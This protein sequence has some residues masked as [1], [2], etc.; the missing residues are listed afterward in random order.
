MDESSNINNWDRVGVNMVHEG[1]DGRLV[2]NWWE[3]ILNCV[4]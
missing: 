2:C 1:L 4:G 3:N